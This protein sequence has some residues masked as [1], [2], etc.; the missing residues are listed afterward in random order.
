[1]LP[2][3]NNRCN[4]NLFI[5]RLNPCDKTGSLGRIILI[6]S[7]FMRKIQAQV[8]YENTSKINTRTSVLVRRF[9]KKQRWG[10]ATELV[11]R[12]LDS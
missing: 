4:H 7:D 12:A 5:G 11:A 9:R 10:S 6:F 1:M 8:S 2:D 3:W